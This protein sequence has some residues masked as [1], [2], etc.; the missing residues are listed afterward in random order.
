VYASKLLEPSGQFAQVWGPHLDSEPCGSPGH[1]LD[2]RQ[3]ILDI[4]QGGD[5]ANRMTSHLVGVSEIATI[6]GVSR[7]RVHQ[8]IEEAADFPMPEAELSAGKVWSRAAVDAWRASH[9]ERLVGSEARTL[10]YDFSDAS[11]RV[12]GR[13]QDESRRLGHPWL[14]TEHL[15]L[16][17]MSGDVPDVRSALGTLKVEREPF[18]AEVLAEA[19]SAPRPDGP[20]PFTQ[21]AMIALQSAVSAAKSTGSQVAEPRHIA[22]AIAVDH[23]SLAARA[24]AKLSELAP[25]DLEDALT[26]GLE[27]AN[28]PVSAVSSERTG[29]QGRLDVSCSF[30]NKSQVSVRKLIA[31]PGIYICDECV[32]LCSDILDEE[33]VARPVGAARKAIEARLEVIAEQV[34]ALSRLLV[35]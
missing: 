3:I 30:C 7:Q 9:P 19:P 26:R 35:E 1:W 29:A 15:A 10:M 28:A 25:Q 6:L 23:E 22:G 27:A 33:R 14:G 17:L 13:A 4:Q 21:R 31:G 16:A 11:R 34:R 24:M 32:G 5:E 8:L 12:I 18:E 2:G 20:V